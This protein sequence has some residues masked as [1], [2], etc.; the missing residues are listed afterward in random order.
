MMQ[1]LSVEAA[2]ASVL[3]PIKALVLSFLLICVWS[4]FYGMV[5]LSPD[6]APELKESI[7]NRVGLALFVFIIGAFIAFLGS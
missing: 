5:E 6:F 7:H 4:L 3:A 1:L 2:E